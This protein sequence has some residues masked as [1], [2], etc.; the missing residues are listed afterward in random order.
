MNSDLAILSDSKF[1]C[2]SLHLADLFWSGRHDNALRDLRAAA[3]EAESEGGE[4]KFELST[5]RNEQGKEQPKLDLT[6]ET[7]IDVSMYIGK[8]R[9]RFR[10]YI[11][12]ASDV[13]ERQFLQLKAQTAQLQAENKKLLNSPERVETEFGT[14]YIKKIPIDKK[15]VLQLD[16]ETGERTRVPASSLE[17]DELLD[18]LIGCAAPRAQGI[19]EAADRLR[20]WRIGVINAQ[21]SRRTIPTLKEYGAGASYGEVIMAA[22]GRKS[23]KQAKYPIG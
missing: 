3:A 9:P 7:L 2:D 19:L 23:C 4:L 1:V 11:K 21:L 10:D 20:N 15:T 22:L 17:Y 8:L 5:Y 6:L 14:K 16:E 18:Y 13:R 12:A